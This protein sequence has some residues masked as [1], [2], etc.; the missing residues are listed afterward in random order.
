MIAR[1]TEAERLLAARGLQA[2]GDPH[3]S[4]DEVDDGSVRVARIWHTPASGRLGASAGRALL[5]V[6][7]DGSMRLGAGEGADRRVLRAGDVLLLTAGASVA[8]TVVEATARIEIEARLPILAR[9]AQVLRA[10]DRDG[11][12]AKAAVVS[13]TNA[14]LNAGLADGSPGLEFF[15]AAI[16][17]CCT[18]LVHELFPDALGAR[19]LGER[20]IAVIARDASDP[21]LSVSRLAERLGVTRQHLA[22][23][24]AQEG[25]R[26]P[27]Q[28][29]R[30]ARADLARAQL[31]SGERT[32]LRYLAR[33]SGFGSE[34]SLR[35]A[36]KDS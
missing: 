3:A 12:W 6:Q 16:G 5:I 28:E 27:L 35:R 10:D 26:T 19:T 11:G 22:F 25:R 21:A 29:I 31:A 2:E 20:A 15:S 9:R 32:S 14:A 8:V 34:D 30:R 13:L 33:T 1:G 24:F 36:L 7:L 23:V 18:A 17:S 4:V